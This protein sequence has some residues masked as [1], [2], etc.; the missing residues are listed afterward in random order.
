MPL[1][2]LV[3]GTHSGMDFWS[4][5]GEMRSL[6]VAFVVEPT[7]PVHVHHQQGRTCHDEIELCN[8]PLYRL[9][10]LKVF[11]LLI[12]HAC[13]TICDVNGGSTVDSQEKNNKQKGG[14]TRRERWFEV[15]TR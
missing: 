8:Q 2:L 9:T 7:F 1:M 6:A 12:H 11:S 10:R 4:L 15:A 3:S 14:R 13:D 5:L